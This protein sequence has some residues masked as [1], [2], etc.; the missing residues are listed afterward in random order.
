MQVRVIPRKGRHFTYNVATPSRK[1]AVKR[2][3]CRTYKSLAATIIDSPN[4]SKGVIAKLA[5]KI[6]EEMK[7]ISSQEHDSILRDPLE[8]VK[9]F[10]WDKVLLE[11][12]Y[13]LPTLVSLVS[14]LIGRRSK[15]MLC[16]IISQLLKARHQHMG[17]VQRAVSVM[18]YG[19]CTAKEVSP[20]K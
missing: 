7:S 12:Q 11:F 18:L 15:T 17:L 14:Q 19:N 4:L 6:K 2:L 8:A 20:I 10:H 3:S 1:K 9:R 13:N 16:M 5:L